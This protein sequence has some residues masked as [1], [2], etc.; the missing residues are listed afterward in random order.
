MRFVYLDYTRGKKNTVKISNFS[1]NEKEFAIEMMNQFTASAGHPRV[2]AFG[3]LR[4]ATLTKTSFPII[5]VLC[6]GFGCGSRPKPEP[7]VEP[8]IGKTTSGIDHTPPQAPASPSDY[9]PLPAGVLSFST[10]IAPIVFQKCVAC[11]RPGEMGPFPLESYAD[12]KK[13]SQQIVEVIRKRL[14][15]PWPA[16]SG[17]CDFQ[18]DRSLTTVEIGKITQWHQEGCLEGDPSA[19]PSLPVFPSGWRLGQPD[20]VIQMSE[21]YTLAADVKDTTRKFVVPI[22]IKQ[23]KYLKGWEFN[24]GNAKI[25]HHALLYTDRT[26][27]SRQLDEMD[28]VPGYD[29]KIMEGERS[30]EDFNGFNVGWNPGSTPAPLDEELSWPL[31]P[32]T[33][34][35]L[36]LH[37][38]GTGKPEPLQSSVALYFANHP[39]TKH[40]G[41]V[42]LI[43]SEIDIPAGEKSY[44]VHDQYVLP[45][46]A[47]LLTTGA[48]AHYLGKDVQSWA[49]FPDGSKKWLLRIED[50]DFNWQNRYT[51]VEPLSLPKGTT[52]HM[53]LTFDNSA[54]NPRNPTIPTVRVLL[55]PKSADE[56]GEMSFNL[57]LNNEHDAKILR[58]DSNRKFAKST[59]QKLLFL[60][61]R[62][63]SNAEAHFAL[64]VHFKAQ[65]D[66][67]RAVSY[68]ERALKVDPDHSRARNNLGTAYSLLGRMS[69][70]VTQYS[71]AI[72]ISPRD[73]RAHNNLGVT[74]LK[75]GE[76]DPAQHHFRTALEIDPK[77]A[78]AEFNLGLIAFRKKDI[79]GAVAHAERALQL[80]PN[81]KP[82]EELIRSLRPQLS[83]ATNSR[84]TTGKF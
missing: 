54:E 42:A 21:P 38:C 41:F 70:A 22:P 57:L 34:L 24:P 50:W 67:K 63:P 72:R 40:G 5:F 12:V 77:F 73:S 55:G 15:P 2:S 11:H 39:P 82:A 64:G 62:D 61:E 69:D 66:L 83:P 65:G 9:S 25:V 36:E 14:M 33:D 48:H 30:P 46:D 47:T 59:F 19:L 10:E 7:I 17:Y 18:Q 53:K 60:S 76:L 29:G 81:Y 58:S 23:L 78:L 26:G 45:V 32:G 79:P 84:P 35:V 31:Y 68:Y 80:N 28:P 6:F 71:E 20:L 74:Y 49:V 27:W 3:H 56:M 8:K 43:A 44:S 4:R 52:L 51:Y 75:L 1:K 16:V 13:R 37:L